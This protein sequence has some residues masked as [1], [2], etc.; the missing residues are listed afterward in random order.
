[1]SFYIRTFLLVYGGSEIQINH[2]LMFIVHLD[3][4]IEI[5]AYFKLV[6]VE[7]DA[8][9]LCDMKRI[10]FIGIARLLTSNLKWARG[11]HFPHH[12][13]LILL[14]FYSIF[15]HI[16]LFSSSVCSS[17]W[18][19]PTPRGRPGYVSLHT[20]SHFFFWGGDLSPK[21]SVLTRISVVA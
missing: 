17:R 9:K 4:N 5:V 20:Q 10:P 13:F 1:M 15:P 2:G 7:F 11:E 16:F 19:T 18:V 12:V 6:T 14:L 21:Y 8:N 3:E